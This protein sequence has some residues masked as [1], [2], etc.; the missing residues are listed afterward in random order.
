MKTSVI[1]YRVADFLREHPP[2]DLFSPEDLLAFSAS[3]RVLFH[4]DDIYLF[5]RG[6]PREPRLW[7][8][9]Q[10]RVEMLDDTPAGVQLRDVL[11]PG[12]IVGY[13]GYVGYGRQTGTEWPSTA[14]TATEVILYAFEAAAFEALAGKYPE[15]AH[16][17][18]AHVSA[19]ARR[20]KALHAP[21]TRERLLTE[22]EKKVWLHVSAPSMVGATPRFIRCGPDAGLAATARLMTEARA[23]A[24]VVTG[25]S[26]CPQGLL[27]D[28]ELRAG[29]AAAMAPGTAI[30][31][32]MRRDFVTAAPRLEIADYMLAMLR[33]RASLLVITADGTA[34]TPCEAIVTETELALRTGRNPMRLIRE[35][36]TAETAAEL[37]WLR[38]RVDDLLMEGLVGPSMVEWSAQMSGEMHAAIVAR[39]VDLATAEMARAGQSP[40]AL[41]ACW[42]LLGRAGRGEAL[43][44]EAPR[45]AVVYGNSSPRLEQQARQYFDTL[46]RKAQ[47][48]LRA[49]G[50]QPGADETGGEQAGLARTLDE[51]SWYFAARIRDP[52]G[53]ALYAA[54]ESFDFRVVCGAAGLAADLRETIL[55]EARQS[56]SFHAVLAH[57]TMANTPPLAFFQGAVIEA[58]GRLKQELDLD[59]T[60]LTPITDAARAMALRLGDPRDRGDPRDPRE[61]DAG[62]TLQRLQRARRAYPQFTSI[63]ADAEA[64]WRI[65]AYHHALA[66]RRQSGAA[67]I[68]PLRLDKFEQRMLKTAFDSTRRFLELAFSF[69]QPPEPQ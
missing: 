53:Q 26:G 15:A 23:E 30:R 17:L 46:A 16:Y 56:E 19:T 8:I 63:L 40:P 59:R 14:R 69:H 54:R 37:A 33:A 5:R 55:S 28:V 62:N 4:E 48:M 25:A 68:Q 31:E 50:Y 64:A 6:E 34:A 35:I 13:V 27:T 2:F 49:C 24:A 41:P 52:I 51:W 45:I 12:D 61:I 18:T 9:Q 20:T 22:A 1:R 66:C 44:A 43:T 67:L 60:A 57:D 47:A 65:V 3:G 38:A 7:V 58:D 32:L 39:L 42:L 21:L 36:T 11:G 10:G 29:V